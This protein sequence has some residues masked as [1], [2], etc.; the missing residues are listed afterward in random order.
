MLMIWSLS[1]TKEGLQNLITAAK[2]ESEKVG[3]GM[4]VKKTKQWLFL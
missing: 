2:I 4:K 3:L 1:D